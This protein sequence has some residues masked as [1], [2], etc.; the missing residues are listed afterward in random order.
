[1]TA[2]LRATPSACPACAAAPSAEALAERAAPKEARLILSLPTAHCAACM[3]TVERGLAKVPGVHDA[4]VNLTLKRVAVAAAPDM[5]AETLI[6]ALDRLGY[7]AHELDPGTLSSTAADKAGR[8]LLMR[9]AVAGFAMMNVMLLSVAI[10]SGAEQA[11]RIM[12]EWIS[13]AIALPTVV[14]SGQPFFR[15]ALA[16]LKARRL[17]MDVPISLA[18]LLATALSFY[19]T[20]VGQG[21]T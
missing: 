4:R 21:H 2:T 1:M 15:S 16:A 20:A 12:F 5:T 14:F 7:E 18:I 8:E 11:T 6:A 9:L 3:S 17:G 13:A 10:W 19:E